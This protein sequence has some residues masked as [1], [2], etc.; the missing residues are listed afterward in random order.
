MFIMI[1]RVI[2]QVIQNKEVKKNRIN[3]IRNRKPY[4]N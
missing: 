4:N 1:V 3:I 2:I